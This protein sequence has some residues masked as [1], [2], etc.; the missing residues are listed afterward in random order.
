MFVDESGAN[1]AMTRPRGRAPPGERVV[2]RV[3]NGH[4][5]TLTMLGA[6]RLDGVVAAATVPAAT[7]APVFRSFVGEALVPSLRRGGRGGLGQPFAAQGG[8]A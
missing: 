3:P 4:W 2:G 5:R 1:T 6:V 8:G 7:D